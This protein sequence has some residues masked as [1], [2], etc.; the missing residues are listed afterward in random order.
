MKLFLSFI[1]KSVVLPAKLAFALFK[2]PVKVYKFMMDHAILLG[3]YA[4]LK[5]MTKV[6][7]RILRQPF[8]LGMLVGSSMLFVLIDK[9]R[10]KKVFA[11]L[12]RR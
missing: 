5:L 4:S 3:I 7:F 6:S 1:K 11:L 12:N 10:R 8:F 2:F 9:K